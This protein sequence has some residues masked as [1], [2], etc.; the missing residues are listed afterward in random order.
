MRKRKEDKEQACPQLTK[1]IKMDVT[2]RGEKRGAIDKCFSVRSQVGF[3]AEN[4][5]LS[6]KHIGRDNPG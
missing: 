3:L 6:Q 2:N 1:K 5:P 4:I